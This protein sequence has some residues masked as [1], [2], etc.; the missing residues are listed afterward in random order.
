MRHRRGEPAITRSPP[1]STSLTSP[2]ADAL[3]MADAIVTARYVIKA[4]A[5]RHGLRATFLPKP[6]YGINGSGMHTHQQL[7]RAGST[8]AN[9]FA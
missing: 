5:Q 7:V 6:F 2:R 8:A 9:A 3:H 1:A 4:V